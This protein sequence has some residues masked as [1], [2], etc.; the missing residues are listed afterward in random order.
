MRL[1][2]I[3]LAVA[4]IFCA[5]ADATAFAGVKLAFWQADFSY[6]SDPA[7]DAPLTV[8][9]P[10]IFLECTGSA[11]P[12]GAGCSDRQGISVTSDGPLVTGLVDA[13]GG[14]TLFNTGSTDYPGSFVF[15]TSFSAFNPGGPE[16]GAS[17]D[18][19]AR[20]SASFFSVVTGPGVFDL[21]GCN[22]THG[23]APHAAAMGASCGVSSPDD[24]E[25]ETDLGPLLAGQSLSAAYNIYIQVVAQGDSPV[26]EPLTLGIFFVGLVAVR[27]FRAA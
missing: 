13:L 18:D 16:I 23:L 25:G 10:G 14:F 17:V 22:M 4:L 24:S 27:R 12:T 6:Y 9:P 8:L 2:T 11:D 19:P 15:H 7:L 26:P 3:A 1:P 21:H 5:R 20:E